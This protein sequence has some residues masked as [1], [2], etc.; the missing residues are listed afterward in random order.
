MKRWVIFLL[1]FFVVGCSKTTSHQ[2]GPNERLLVGS[3]DLRQS[4]GG[5]SG[6]VNYATRSFLTIVFDTNGHHQFNYGPAVNGV[7]HEG[8]Y[9]LRPSAR[10]GDW[11]LFLHYL[12]ANQQAVVDIDSVRVEANKL[13]FLPVA[14]CCDIPTLFYEKLP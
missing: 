12:N 8:L 10:K 14:D 3:W 6:T 13:I 2:V 1:I 9:E 7:R 4:I 5:I 11:L